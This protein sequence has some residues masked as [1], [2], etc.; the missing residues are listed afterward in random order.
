MQFF[1]TRRYLPS[2][3]T[4]I[5]EDWDAQQHCCENLE[6]FTICGTI[7]FS[8]KALFCEATWLNSLVHHWNLRLEIADVFWLMKTV[9]KLWGGQ[10]LSQLVTW[11]QN[12][13]SLCTKILI[14]YAFLLLFILSLAL[15]LLSSSSSLSSLSSLSSSL[16]SLSSSVVVSHSHRLQHANYDILAS[17]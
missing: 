9:I 3:T 10:M 17:C 2:K 8:R 7:S 14:E 15:L 6:L 16:S 13:N 1:A 12:F 11:E 4:Y 5:P